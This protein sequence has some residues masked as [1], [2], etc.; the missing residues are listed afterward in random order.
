MAWIP[1]EFWSHSGL[2][3]MN[4]AE[5]YLAARLL[6]TAD[7]WGRVPV[8]DEALVALA[9]RAGVDDDDV[10]T[11]LDKATD[12]RRPFLL[13]YHND[14]WAQIVGFDDLQRA[15]FI[16]SR[17]AP[18]TPEPP[19]EVWRGARCNR[20]YRDNRKAEILPGH[21]GW[22][23][24]AATKSDDLVAGDDET[25]SSRRRR[26]RNTDVAG[27]DE[28]SKSRRHRRH[29][30]DESSS[31]GRDSRHTDDENQDL[32]SARRHQAPTDSPRVRAQLN[33]T[34]PNKNQNARAHAPARI[35]TPGDDPPTGV[36]DDTPA[37]SSPSEG[38]E[39]PA[40]TT[41]PTHPDWPDIKQ[42]W[43]DE[44]QR[45]TN[46][47]PTPSGRYNKGLFGDDGLFDISAYLDNLAKRYVRILVVA[48]PEYWLVW[49][50]SEGSKPGRKRLY[51]P[52]I[53]DALEMYLMDRGLPTPIQ[54]QAQGGYG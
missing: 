42:A 21:P 53:K 48:L 24:E 46:A 38:T 36:R 23:P 7:K 31:V 18:E 47:Q 5:L 22:Y 29:T 2:K 11:F 6:D 10:D 17:P 44:Y 13:C 16:I 25:P 1:E 15:R 41:K 26:R 30:D 45:R 40:T 49:D 34:Q 37:L 28:E 50:E 52:K 39:S 12:R 35:D 27:D 51:P 19:L 33:P 9:D 3:K 54:R 43:I 4:C 20:K 8:Y 14:R 32:A